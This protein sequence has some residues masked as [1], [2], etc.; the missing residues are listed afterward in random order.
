MDTWETY[1]YKV[2]AC[3]LPAI[4]NG[5]I[6]GLCVEDLAAL[7]RFECDLPEGC[8]LD[9]RLLEGDYGQCEVTSL[10][11]DRALLLATFEHEGVPCP[12]RPGR[13][14]HEQGL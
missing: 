9:Y 13:G 3:L 7:D 14:I 8:S 5:D 1:E 6:E 10:M 4:I 12:E 2:A 11:A